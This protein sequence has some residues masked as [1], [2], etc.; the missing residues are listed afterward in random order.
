MRCLPR[1]WFNLYIEETDERPVP[2]AF[3]RYHAIVPVFSGQE[4]TN[5]RA[6]P[7]P[8]TPYYVMISQVLQSE[9]SAV[10]VDRKTPEAALAAAQA[11]IEQIL[12]R[13]T[14]ATPGP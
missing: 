4:D 7:R 6:R 14:A 8:V 10:L 9:F 13:T 2:H 12:K 11:Q 5:H 3:A 1:F